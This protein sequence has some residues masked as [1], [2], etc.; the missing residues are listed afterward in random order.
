MLTP[1]PQ[2]S[3]SQLDKKKQTQIIL[4]FQPKQA[5]LFQSKRNKSLLVIDATCIRGSANRLSAGQN[6]LVHIRP[7]SVTD[8]DV[9]N[10]ARG[11]VGVDSRTVLDR[12]TWV[13]MDDAASSSGVVLVVK[14]DPMIERNRKGVRIVECTG[15]LRVGTEGDEDADLV[16]SLFDNDDGE[17]GEADDEQPQPQSVSLKTERHRI[18]AHWLVDTYGV[19]ALSKGSGVL[20]V[21]GG[22]GEISNTLHKLGVPSTLLDP[23]PRC[24]DSAPFTALAHALNGDGSDLTDR[25]DH[26]GDI[27]RR[28]S[29]VCGMH[30]DQATEPIVVLALRLHVPFAVL[31]CC[32]MPRLFPARRQKRHGDPVRSY[33]AFCLYL[34]DMAPE[35]GGGGDATASSFCTHRLNFV[36]RNKVIY[37]HVTG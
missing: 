6:C 13:T 1:P 24:A 29:F 14:A 10:F 7:D 32:V 2:S 30:P 5:K 37:S 21:A 16:A 25:N 11:L 23:N 17:E 20:D 22:N 9:P 34:L 3:S 28:C 12:G 8:G 4:S 36:G 19:E 33:K 26:V 27:V 35:G 18:F 15:I 31:P